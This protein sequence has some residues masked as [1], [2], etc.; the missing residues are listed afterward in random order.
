MFIKTSSSVLRNPRLHFSLVLLVHPK[1][2]NCVRITSASTRITLSEVSIGTQVY[3]VVNTCVSNKPGLLAPA[4]SEMN[5]FAA[6]VILGY[7]HCSSNAHADAA[8]Y[9]DVYS[10]DAAIV[11]ATLSILSIIALSLF[12][13]KIKGH[14]Y[15]SYP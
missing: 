13:Y 2:T 12:C 1:K 10:D 11:E 7:I 15:I 4:L 8:F 14:I 3:P 5:N 9:N 6:T